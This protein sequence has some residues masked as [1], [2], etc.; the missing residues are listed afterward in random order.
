MS[1]APSLRWRAAGA[2]RPSPHHVENEDAWQI[3]ADVPGDGSLCVV[4]DGVSNA[5]AGHTAARL[6]CARLGQ[7]EGR[8]EAQPED[9]LVQLVSEIDW[10]LRGTSGGA[11]CTLAMAWVDGLTAHI[12]TVGDSPVYRL[13]AG[14]M[15]QAGSEK[16]GAF[17]RLQAYLGMGPKVSDQLT[18]D[19]WALAP[20]D[21]LF[22]LSDGVLNAIDED[23]LADGW[24]RTRDPERCARAVLDEVARHGVDDDATVV[25]LEIYEDVALPAPA[26]PREAPDP[27]SRLVWAP[28]DDR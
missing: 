28:P 8:R 14:R 3:Y 19:R 5:G 17:R 20:G 15:K 4:C 7:F 2:S 26:S 16:T 10:E 12:F 1:G 13:R 23:D 22:L 25:V 9:A 24:A 21:V 6:A 11:K 27:P 18:R